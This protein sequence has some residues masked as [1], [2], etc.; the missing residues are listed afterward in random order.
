MLNMMTVQPTDAVASETIRTRISA[1][2]LIKEIKQ[3]ITCDVRR[4]AA[5]QNA[6]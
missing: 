3:T 6:L 5:A 2:L 1:T 4:Y